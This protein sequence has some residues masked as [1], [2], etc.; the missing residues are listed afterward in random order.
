M[1]ISSQFYEDL[2]KVEKKIFGVTYRQAKASVLLAG[3]TAV[4]IVEVFLLPDWAFYFVAIPTV[5]LMGFY[6]TLLLINKW[7]VFKRW[8]E[9]KFLYE[10]SFYYTGQIRRYEKHEFIPKKG[11]SETDKIEDGEEIEEDREEA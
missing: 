3:V 11:V 1:A 7:R 6:P 5:G 8:L 9:L 10:N 4:S 2:S